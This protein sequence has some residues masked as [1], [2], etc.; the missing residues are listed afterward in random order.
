MFSS[1]VFKPST[2]HW[3]WLIYLDMNYIQ[4]VIFI[5]SYQM[6]LTFLFIIYYF[7]KHF[8]RFML[9]WFVL[10]F[11]RIYN[12]LKNVYPQKYTLRQYIWLSFCT[13]PFQIN[14][15]LKCH[16]INVIIP[17]SFW[18][19]VHIY[20]SDRILMFFIIWHFNVCF[21]NFKFP[22]S[23]F[24]QSGKKRNVF[25]DVMLMKSFPKF[26]K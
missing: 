6:E 15:S 18:S 12:V 17:S 1:F 11:E 26:E 3:T 23:T 4:I 25:C 14:A 16:F 10:P 19:F 22:Y 7:T 21:L 5:I 2:Y 13:L 24:F 8:W 20:I 9:F